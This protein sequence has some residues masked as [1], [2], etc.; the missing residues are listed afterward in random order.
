MAYIFDGGNQRLQVFNLTVETFETIAI[1]EIYSAYPQTD[2]TD[3]GNRVWV[4]NP[5]LPSRVLYYDIAGVEIGGYYPYGQVVDP[6][7]IYIDYLDN[8][9]V[10]DYAQGWVFKYAKNTSYLNKLAGANVNNLY[11]IAVS[12]IDYIYLAINNIIY[13][14]Y[15][16]GTLF[17]TTL[18]P[19][20]HTIA[21]IAVTPT[22]EL[23]I[24]DSSTHQVLVYDISNIT[25]TLISTFGGNGSTNG[26]FLSPVAITCNMKHQI[27]YIQDILPFRI[28]AFD[29]GGQFLFEISNSLSGNFAVDFDGNIYILQ[30]NTFVIYNETGQFLFETNIPI[31]NNE[32]LDNTITFAISS[33][34]TI[35]ICDSI[36]SKIAMYNFAISHSSKVSQS[37]GININDNT[38]VLIAI[39][40]SSAVG[41]TAII[42]A[43]LALLYFKR[44]SKN[45]K[46]KLN[47]EKNPL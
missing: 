13:I 20:T 40:A 6:Q 29:L 3:V 4:S 34:G 31:L 38:A 7:F 33:N 5:A 26:K 1:C 36:H 12:P 28:Q 46:E 30:N 22:D 45:K 35:F 15:Q 24:L 11:K 16:N 17:N 10:S 43:G 44:C 25:M 39:S 47:V 42:S 9:Y 32:F 18:L 23:F 37:T 14:Y 27:I 21:G 19:T 41:A 2:I 8:I